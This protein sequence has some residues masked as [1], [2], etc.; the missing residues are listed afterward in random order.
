MAFIMTVGVL[1]ILVTRFSIEVKLRKM[2]E[3]NK[4]I[5]KLLKQI[6]EQ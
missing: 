4:E 2:S 3:Q 6:K 1:A 5:I